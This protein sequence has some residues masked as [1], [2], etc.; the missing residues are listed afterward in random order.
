[1]KNLAFS[2]FFLLKI[3]NLKSELTTTMHLS[4]KVI[5]HDLTNHHSGRFK[6]LKFSLVFFSILLFSGF[7]AFSVDP[8]VTVRFANPEFVCT[9]Q[10][11]SLDVEFQCNTANKELFGM[12]VRFFYPENV[13]EF[14]SFGEFAT[15]YGPALPNPPLKSTGNESSGMALFGFLGPQEYINGAIQKN[16]ADPLVYLSTTGWTKLFNVSFHVDDPAALNS[17][18]FCP[19]VIWD[20]NEA[21]TG[22]IN[23]SGGIIITLTVTY[24]NL[25]SPATENC[26]Q[27]NWQYDGIPGLPH[28]NPLPTDCVN[29]ICAY[30]PE[31][32]LPTYGSLNPGIITL[33]VLVNDFDSI[34]A[35]NLAFEYDP[36]VLTYVNSAPNAIFNTTNGL[37]TVTDSASTGGLKKI[38]MSFNGS[39]IS[40]ADSSHLADLQFNYI[41]GMTSLTWKTDSTSCKYIN[42]FE[43]PSYDIPYT[44]YYINGVAASLT[45][46]VTKI[47]SVVAVQGSFAT[48]TIRVWDYFKILSGQLTLNYVPE[49]L[50]F[51]HIL[52]ND[53]IDSIFMAEVVTPGTLQMEWTGRVPTLAD[54][55]I[56]MYVTFQYQGGISDLVWYDNGASCQYINCE[57]LIPLTDVP[58]DTHYLN[59]NVADAVVVWTGENS[60]DWNA[61]GNWND[62]ITPNQSVDV[63]IDPSVDPS[64]WPVFNGDFTIGVNCDNLTLNDNAFMT[65]NGNFMINP[66]HTLNLNGN[67]IIEIAGDWINSGIFNP[68]NGTVEFTGSDDNFLTVGVDPGNYIA[69]YVM[70]SFAPGLLFLSGGMP[71]PSGDNA[72]MDVNIGFDFSFLNVNYSQVRINTNGWISLNHTGDDA[73]SPDNTLLFNT[74]NPTTVLAPWWDDLKADGSTSITYKTEGTTPSRVFTVEWKNILAF[75]SVASSRLN[76]QVKLYEGTHE[77]EFCYGTVTSG[78]H[79]PAEGASIG[80][81]DLT[82]GSGNFIEATQNSNTIIIAFLLSSLDWPETNLR[83]SPPVVNDMDIFH[84]IVVNKTGGRLFI[85]KDVKITGLN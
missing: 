25:S 65:I 1:M 40:L 72:H 73:S 23:P 44:D 16:A 64:N 67:G 7:K 79:S 33:P 17:Q 54:G 78:T 4:K 43:I 46:P 6:H 56:L 34:S 21:Q 59:G 71:G 19:P 68:G 35:F 83:F 38:R 47:D 81:K 50:V 2:A 39:V 15:G 9:T 10:T 14:L 27:F 29:T 20:L 75:S 52:P 24:P 13:L 3:L 74:S 63:I 28:G 45:A 57:L 58:S 49:V 32:I 84:K 8:V 5:Y 70:S 42:Q 41:S 31:T 48:F 77:I 11:Y 22:G 30:A 26:Q 76:F 62:D 66:G 82:G 51:H 55:S 18:S 85:Q 69:S 60:G 37:L 80:L 12:N 36:S 61:E 53:D